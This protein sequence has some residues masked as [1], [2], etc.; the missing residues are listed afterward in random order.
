VVGCKEEKDWEEASWVGM[1]SVT[2]EGGVYPR[3]ISSRTSNFQTSP[4]GLN[5][6][7]AMPAQI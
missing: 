2:A 5:W 6:P 4:N 3:L 1:P 7:I